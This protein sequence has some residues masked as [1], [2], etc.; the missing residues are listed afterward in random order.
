MTGLDSKLFELNFVVIVV[1]NRPAVAMNKDILVVVV[2]SL[3]QLSV[4]MSK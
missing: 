3:K 4:A 2:Q 1:L